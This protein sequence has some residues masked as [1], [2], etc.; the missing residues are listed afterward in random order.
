MKKSILL[1]I[2]A[3]LLLN[4]A[5]ASEAKSVPSETVHHFWAFGEAPD[6][7]TK[8]Q[9]AY[10]KSVG[11]IKKHH[12]IKKEIAKAMQHK[13]KAPVEIEEGLRDTLEAINALDKK[14]NKKAEQKLQK[15]IALFDKA[16]KKDPALKLVPVNTDITLVAHQITLADAKKIKEDALKLLKED[17]PQE[18]IAL[19][20]LLKNELT[21]TTTAI[22]M[23]LYPDA[24]KLALKTLKEDKK[25]S[26]A[27]AILA[28]GIDTFVTTEVV[29]P[30]SLMVVESA[31]DDASK[32]E[33]TQKK[34]A[35][36]LLKIAQDQL[37][38]AHYEGYLSKHD[39]AYK[40]LSNE[41]KTLRKK[42]EGEGLIAKDFDKFKEAFKKMF[43]KIHEGTQTKKKK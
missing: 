16:L 35:L 34:E 30:L 29:V 40:M 4:G 2:T 13:T 41:I 6:H 24:A 7:L 17:K 25:P 9:I 10:F 39:K 33:K 22:P 19:L 23:D 37:E 21:I 5:Y 1:S 26:K 28:E 43:D 12:L 14:E 38:L 36:S 11:L 18:A 20:E 15:A 3:A 27:M 42:A 32:L 31:I 8:D